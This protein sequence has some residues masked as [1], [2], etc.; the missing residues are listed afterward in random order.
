MSLDPAEVP[1]GGAVDLSAA[2]RHAMLG[3]ASRLLSTS[4]W[5]SPEGDLT[6]VHHRRDGLDAQRQHF[7]AAGGWLPSMIPAS[8]SRHSFEVDP[9]VDVRLPRTT[10]RLSGSST[11]RRENVWPFQPF[12]QGCYDEAPASR[13]CSGKATVLT[14]HGFGTLSAFPPP[15]TLGI[16]PCS[17]LSVRPL[18]PASTPGGLCEVCDP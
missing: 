16:A 9:L 15:V 4:S 8:C 5:P 6:S 13:L 1:V 3:G 2:R 17:P 10:P 12:R 18:L 11:T 14:T 7:A